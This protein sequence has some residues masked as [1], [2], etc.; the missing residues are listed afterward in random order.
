MKQKINQAIELV[1][2]EKK[3]IIIVFAVFLSF[4]ILG[5]MMPEL[6]APFQ[7]QIIDSLL[8]RFE[9]QN[10]FGYFF[11]ILAQNAFS[12][13]ITILLGIT[14]LIPIFALTFNGLFAG[15]VTM[16]KSQEIGA[17][18]FLMLLPHG[19]FEIPAFILAITFGL[20]IFLGLFKEKKMGDSYKEALIVYLYIIIPLL[21]L[22]A[23]IET[24]LIFVQGGST[25]RTMA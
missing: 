15:S 14:L 25:L 9:G 23:L 1:K 22:A 11:L 12:T 13:L 21:V 18:A 10:A 2:Q 8:E 7:D 16:Q 24:T 5:T 3:L 17:R 4:F 19:I 20:R 6:T